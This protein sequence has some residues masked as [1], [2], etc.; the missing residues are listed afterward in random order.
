VTVWNPPDGVEFTWNPG[1]PR[2]ERQTVRVEFQVEADGTRVT[3]THRGWQ[4]AGVA[5]C[6]SGSAVTAGPRS[7]STHGSMVCVGPSLGSADV[8]LGAVWCATPGSTWAEVLVE[9][10]AEFAARRM[11]AAA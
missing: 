6:V 8:A 5:V 10:F 3:L 7:G 11:M 1:G 4:Y 2:D 9:R